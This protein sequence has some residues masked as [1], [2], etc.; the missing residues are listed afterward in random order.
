LETQENKA[1]HGGWR[2]GGGRPPGSTARKREV[3]VRLEPVAFDGGDIRPLGLRARDYTGLSLK[4]YVDVLKNPK[5][6]DGDKIRAATEILNRGWGKA[7]ENV[8]VTT[9]NSFANLSDG[10]IAATLANIRAALAMGARY[11][12][13]TD[14]TADTT[15]TDV[16]G[17]ASGVSTGEASPLPAAETAEGGG[18]P[19]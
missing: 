16:V 5:A 4:A 14:V 17:E 3:K 15:I 2:P 1:K 12:S 7:A 13:A 10:D 19:Q 11:S 8:N 9:I 6:Q 18:E